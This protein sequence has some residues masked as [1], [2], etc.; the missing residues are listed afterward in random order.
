MPAFK[1]VKNLKVPG[2]EPPR[3]AC[4]DPNC[5]WHGTLK[6][7]GLI[8]EGFVEKA[9]ARKMA[10]VRHDYL[11]YSEKYKRYERR[12]SKIHA[13]IPECIKV[14]PGQKVVIGECRPIAKTVKFVVLGVKG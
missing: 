12:M 10:V 2:V 6:V 5:P 11:Y 1:L 4:K 13:H 3:E 9:K 14:E 8:L 7:R